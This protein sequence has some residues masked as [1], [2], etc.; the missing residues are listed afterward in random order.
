[1]TTD[2]SDTIAVK[3]VF[4]VPASVLFGILTDERDLA[5]LTRAETKFE[6]KEGGTFSFFGASVLGTVS[7]LDIDAK[8]LVLNWRFSSWAP[9]SASQ[10]TIQC[11]DKDRNSSC[12]ISIIH[13][14]I[15]PKDK[16]GNVDQDRLC[17]AGWEDRW[18]GGLASVLG[19]PRQN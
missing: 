2:H 3:A 1:M 7:R 11:T 6:K 19:L 5:R 8:T 13:T 16:F 15:P 18:I 9:D 14:G 17:R 10:V 4:H 12:E